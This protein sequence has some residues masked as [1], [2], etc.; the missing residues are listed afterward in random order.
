MKILTAD[1]NDLLLADPHAGAIC[2]T[3]NQ[4]LRSHAAPL[5]FSSYKVEGI[6]AKFL[7]KCMLA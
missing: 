6:K 1:N 4:R 2:A 7:Q 3:C 5:Q